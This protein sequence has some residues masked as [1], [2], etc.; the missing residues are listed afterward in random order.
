[1]SIDDVLDVLME[2]V[3]AQS[4]KARTPLPSA[5]ILGPLLGESLASIKV[6]LREGIRL[7][8]FWKAPD[9]TILLAPPKIRRNMYK[10][11]SISASIHQM[12]HQMTSRVLSAGICEAAKE[13]ASALHLPLGGRV[14][15]LHRVRSVDGEP[16][17]IEISTLP[18]KLFPHLCNYDF[19]VRSLYQVL[20]ERYQCL[21]VSQEQEFILGFPTPEESRLLHIPCDAEL[22]IQLGRTA[23][24]SGHIFEYSVS[25]AVGNRFEYELI[26]DI[27]GYHAEQCAHL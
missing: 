7:G 12:G 2:Y 13:E 1:M 3:D 14:F 27:E 26:T 23:D 19:G 15:R 21:A 8:L 11:S 6:A 10:M 18:D 17:L 4:L 25:K 9:G 24:K 16:L 22:M 5:E 20:E